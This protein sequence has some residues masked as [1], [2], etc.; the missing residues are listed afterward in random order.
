[1]L[2]KSSFSREQELNVYIFQIII[3]GFPE[4]PVNYCICPK[5]DDFGGD[6]LPKYRYLTSDVSCL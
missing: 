2:Y 5:N 6:L 1:M 4:I 3:K